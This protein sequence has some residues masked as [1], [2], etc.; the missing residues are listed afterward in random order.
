MRFIKDP[1]QSTLF[2]PYD[3]VLND[4]VRKKL[5]QGWQGLLRHVLLEVMPVEVLAAK[6]HET[7]GCPSKELYSVAG[8]MLVKESMDWTQEQ[9]VEQYNLNIGVQYALNVAPGGACMSSR[10]LRRYQDILYGE[11]WGADVFERVTQKLLESL[12]LDVSEQRLD[13]THVFSNMALLGRTQ[14]MGVA[15]KRFLTQLIRHDRPA[16]EALD[17]A[18]RN[19]YE[20]SA[21]RLFGDTKRDSESRTVLR[22]Q[23]AEDMFALVRRFEDDEKHNNRTSYKRMRQVFFEQCEVQEDK[24]TLKDK[25]GGRVMQNPSDPNATYDG[26]KG[27]GYQVQ[28]VETC[29]QDNDVQL[30][31]GALAQ[32]AADTDAESFITI[33]GLLK[34][35]DRLPVSILADAAY[36]SDSNAQAAAAEDVDLVSPVNTSKRNDEM[37]H[38]EDFDVNP[39]TMEVEACPAGHTPLDSVHNPETG[40]TTTHMNPETCQ[41]C[42]EKDRCPVKGTRTRTFHHTGAQYRRAQRYRAEQSSQWREHYAKRAGVEGLIGR[43]KRCTGLGHLRVRGR[44]A[45]SHAIYLKL[46]GWNLM[47]AAKA[48]AMRKILGKCAKQA[49]A[50]LKFV[51]RALRSP[52]RS[53]QTPLTTLSRYPALTSTPSAPNSHPLLSSLCLKIPCSKSRGFRSKLTNRK[54]GCPSLCR[55]SVAAQK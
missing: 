53:P 43:L 20:P 32:T 49:F 17:E 35:G 51:N 15:V 16:Y 27:S 7:M 13:S 1:R 30:V 8:L 21:N 18:L 23:V 10:T 28:I 55:S 19:R 5:D 42:P 39:E 46:A 25:A 22:Q 44:P 50:C 6:R 36:G 2:D 38:V 29:S 41:S 52:L 34:E 24:T 11:D 9:A 12:Q 3:Y 26:K 45:V 14:L 31:T 54:R 40:K 47:Q 48:P 4:S 33:L 37:L